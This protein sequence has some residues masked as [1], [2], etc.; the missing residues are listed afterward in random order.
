MTFQREMWF[1]GTFVG[2]ALVAGLLP[3]RWCWLAAVA[4][5]VANIWA[6]AWGFELFRDPVAE[7]TWGFFLGW[8][9]L[10]LPFVC[11]PPLIAWRIVRS[12]KSDPRPTDDVEDEDPSDAGWLR[13]RQGRR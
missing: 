3:R 13:R 6:V 2:T 5:C 4:G 8:S 12:A 7:G 10:W 1:L 9:P 11:A